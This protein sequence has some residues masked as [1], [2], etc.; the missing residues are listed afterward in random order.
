[1]GLYK[2]FTFHEANTRVALPNAFLVFTTIMDQKVQLLKPLNKGAMY[3]T[4]QIQFL[5]RYSNDGRLSNLYTVK[6]SAKFFSPILRLI[7]C[8]IYK[9]NVTSVKI[10]APGVK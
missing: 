1:V 10:L 7:F 5:F 4:K 3:T 2:V 6:K 9:K 8:G